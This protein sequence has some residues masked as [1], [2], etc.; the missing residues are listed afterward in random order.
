MGHVY[1]NTKLISPVTNE[2]V[3]LEAL[4]FKVDPRTGKIEKTEILLLKIK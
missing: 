4:A 3:M 2:G 1:V